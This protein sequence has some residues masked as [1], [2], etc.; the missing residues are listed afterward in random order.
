MLNSLRLNRNER[1]EDFP[2]NI[3]LKIFKNVPR[4]HVGK[5]PDQQNIYYY[6]SK[7]LKLK[8]N[9]LLLFSGIDGSLKKI[10]ETMLKAW[11][12]VAFIDPS[13]AMYNVYSSIYKV[14]AIKIS[15]NQNFRLEKDKL[16]RAIK[17]ET[18]IKKL[19]LKK[20]KISF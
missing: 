18:P 2:R 20:L 12:T 5:Y 4:Y 19:V 14:K 7:F 17:N 9:N 1:V 10:F 3:L 15:Y 13:Y 8:K 16:I 6:L 11:D